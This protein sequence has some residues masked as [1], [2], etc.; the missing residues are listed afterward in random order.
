MSPGLRNSPLYLQEG[1]FVVE[2][3]GLSTVVKVARA[4]PDALAGGGQYPTSWIRNEVT[5][6]RVRDYILLYDLCN[7]RVAIVLTFFF[8]D[9][10][11]T[12]IL[13]NY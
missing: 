7:F 4:R 3:R 10:T 9:A 13:F 2:C 6:K 11:G 8:C 1:C 12:L 5:S